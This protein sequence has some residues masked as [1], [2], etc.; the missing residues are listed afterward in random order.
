MFEGIASIV[1][2]VDL[3]NSRVML[4]IVFRNYCVII[5]DEIWKYFH[6]ALIRITMDGKS[7]INTNRTIIQVVIQEFAVTIELLHI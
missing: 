5:K 1:D 4:L 6:N 2:F 7:I 3:D